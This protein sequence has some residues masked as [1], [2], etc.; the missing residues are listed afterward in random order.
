MKMNQ[1]SQQNQQKINSSKKNFFVDLKL[2]PKI[3]K[4]MKSNKRKK[5]SSKS[6]ALSFGGVMTKEDFDSILNELINQQYAE[7]DL[8]DIGIDVYGFTQGY[9]RAVFNILSIIFNEDQHNAI[10]YFLY[11]EP[12]SPSY[13]L[14]DTDPYDD[15]ELDELWEVV[16]KLK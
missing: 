8:F 10:N 1:Q 7:G 5:H 4:V 12:I 13:V 16:Q 3:K 15:M 9:D 11:G 6:T 2:D 14:E